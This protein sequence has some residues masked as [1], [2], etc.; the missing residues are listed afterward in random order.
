MPAGSVPTQPR[1]L[2]AHAR[3]RRAAHTHC[4]VV[5]L[6]AVAVMNA[7]I[8]IDRQTSV[9]R[10][11]AI[12]T[13]QVA[14]LNRIRIKRA[15]LDHHLIAATCWSIAPTFH[16]PERREPHHRRAW[17]K[18]QAEISV[19]A[20]Y[21][22]RGSRKPLLWGAA[23][24]EKAARERCARARSLPPAAPLLLLLN[25]RD[26]SAAALP[27]PRRRRRAH[28]ARH[29]GRRDDAHRAEHSALAPP[30]G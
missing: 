8:T 4:G 1:T 9:C 22:Q 29:G 19:C 13:Q 7:C 24:G 6:Y 28:D 10:V 2:D 25:R 5:T 21:K 15:S 18:R 27:P 23:G 20:V 26:G 14:V 12:A 3:A 11:R 30:V 16:N 17:T